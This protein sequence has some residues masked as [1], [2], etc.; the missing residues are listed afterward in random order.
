M[1][2]RL[3]EAPAKQAFDVETFREHVLRD[4]APFQLARAISMLK[5]QVESIEGELCSIQ[6]ITAT[7]E[8]G[9]DRFPCGLEAIELPMPPLQSVESITYLDESGTEQTFGTMQG[10]PEEALE[11]AVE[12]NKA[13]K[14]GRIYLR[15]GYSWPATRCEPNAVRIRF[16]CGFGDCADNVPENIKNWIYVRAASMYQTREAEITGTIATELKYVDRL[17]DKYRAR[18]MVF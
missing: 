3:I 7:W 15:N 16:A 14:F 1:S 5:A 6:L 11:Y 12:R 10:S 17:L 2:L 18:K 8:L 9:L 4:N 13:P